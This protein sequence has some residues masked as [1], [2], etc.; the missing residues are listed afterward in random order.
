[1]SAITIDKRGTAFFAVAGFEQKDVLKSAGFWWHGLPCTR[2]ECPACQAGLG[3]HWWTAQRET[4]ARLYGAEGVEISSAALPDLRAVVES[5][6]AS[7]ALD[8][9]RLLPVPEGLEYLP[10]QRAGIAYALA[11]ARCMIGDEMGLG[12]T[13]QALGVV[14]AD[15]TISRV[16]VICPATLRRNWSREA[17]KWLCRPLPQVIIDV[18]R[19][20]L[21]PPAGPLLAIVNYERVRRAACLEFLLANGSFDLVIVDEA[22]RLKSAKS[23]QTIAVFGKQAKREEI[24]RVGISELARRLL[25]LTGTP[26]VNRPIEL[27]PMIQACAPQTFPSFFRFAKRYAGGSMGAYGWD[28]SGATNLDELQ[29]KL[30]GSMLVRRLKKDVLREL[31]PKRRQIVELDSEGLERLIEQERAAFLTRGE[32]MAALQEEADA[33]H[34]MGD[35]DEYRICV[36]RLREASGIAFE[37]MARM[38]RDLAVAKAPKVAE[39]VRMLLEEEEKLVVFGHHHEVLDQIAAYLEREEIGVV[40]IDG[41][42]PM[43]SRQANVDA[44]Q[45]DDRIRVFI[46]GITAAGVGLTLTRAHTVVFAELDW[47]PGNITQAEDRC[48]RIGQEDTVLVQHLVVQGSLDANMAQTLVYKQDIAD[49]ALD[50]TERERLAAEPVVPA[51]E[52]ERRPSKYPPSTAEQRAALQAALGILAQ[53]SPDGTLLQNEA[54]FSG[55]TIKPGMD[56]AARGIHTDGQAWLARKIV[57]IHRRQLPPDLV[58]AGG[59]EEVVSD[60]K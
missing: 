9:D 10:F 31:P 5:Q 57:R 13:I 18:D 54:G 49:K 23:Q 44:F 58:T 39:H 43:D 56:L 52:R 7:R 3:K 21:F 17:Q 48:H 4:A 8:S 45:T 40:M 60:G 46:G 34:A 35:T 37:E 14:N 16:L 53:L 20:L 41:R 32:T 26:I 55:A 12:K 2:V 28:F 25:L 50:A 27:W 36:R 47:V 24:R 33:A 15:D 11:H 19:P 51:Q 59:V 6:E 1:M 30:R 22:H 38:R 29:D 42:T